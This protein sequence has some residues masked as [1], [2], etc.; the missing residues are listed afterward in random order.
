MPG[1]ED[2]EGIGSKTTS[3]YVDFFK[4]ERTKINVDSKDKPKKK[5]KKRKED[6]IATFVLPCH[7]Q[8]F[9]QTQKFKLL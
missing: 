5:K 8:K 7:P 9:S 3:Y 1:V 4:G 2:I 6:N